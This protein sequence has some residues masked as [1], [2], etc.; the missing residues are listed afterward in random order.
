M[1]LRVTYTQSLQLRSKPGEDRTKKKPA[2]LPSVDKKGK[3][4]RLPLADKKG[5]RRKSGETEPLQVTS[6]NKSPRQ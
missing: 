3:A 2:R 1:Y 4:A 6:S 5:A